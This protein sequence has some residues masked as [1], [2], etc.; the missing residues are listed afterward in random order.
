MGYGLKEKYHFFPFMDKYQ[1]PLYMCI[2]QPVKANNFEEFGPL[3]TKITSPNAP[4]LQA[5]WRH[6]CSKRI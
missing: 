3:Q 4:D 1:K 6:L 5:D 2:H